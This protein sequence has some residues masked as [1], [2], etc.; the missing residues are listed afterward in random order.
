[1]AEVRRFTIPKGEVDHIEF[2][3]RL[4]PEIHLR[5]EKR[6]KL[7]SQMKHR[8]ELG[9]GTAVYI[10]G[11][12][13]D[14]TSAGI[15]EIELEESLSVLKQIAADC[16]ASVVK[17]E[18]F[19]ENGGVIAKVL[20]SSSAEPSSNHVVVSVAGHVNHGKSTFLAC[21]ITGEKD[22]GRK[23]LY[24]DT[25]PH[26]VERNLSADLHFAVLG[27]KENRPY[28]VKNPLD[29]NERSRVMRESDKIVSF[30]DTVG[31]E[32][33][34]RTTIRG[35]L[36][37]EIDYGILVIAADDG[38]THITREH[39]GIMLAM[40]LP[41]AVC[42]TKI[43]KVKPERVEA[44]EKEV[45]SLLKRV[46][47]IPISINSEADISL[48][49]DKLAVV[50]PLLKTSAVSREG[51]DLVYNFLR[52]LPVRPRRSDQP[53]LLYVD[54]V[55]NVEGV[56]A[57]VSG[58]VKQGML[59]AGSELLIGPTAKGRY[60]KVRAR[61]IEMHYTRLTE[62]QPGCIVG[63]AVKGVREDLIKR[64][65]VLCDPSLEPRSVWSFEADV[66]VL[67]HPTRIG[68]GYEPIVHAHTIASTARVKMVDK[69]Y[70]KAGES[71]KVE[72]RFKYR[73][74]YLQTGDR[75]VFRE[76]KTKGIG[77]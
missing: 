10:L 68:D 18:R 25:L 4:I 59:R 69:P 13:D 58:S 29:R 66:T 65:M 50:V 33:W 61:S 42:I 2:K 72:M 11:V 74:F 36:G 27:F 60:V 48:V 77:V 44:V 51:Y 46:G 1:M 5:V 41:V 53:F 14:G 32:P 49:A 9:D 54:R 39:L 7:A 37:Q 6:Q 31:H 3:E 21:L 22:D 8:L 67:S 64:G 63:I 26:E 35:L 55:Y 24:L 38:P 19:S 56:G 62:A 16:G 52:S 15:S 47:R 76:G 23:W 71:G 20:L 75:F 34:L 12:R 57:V 30:V 70:L 43:D 73:P 17:V 45:S 28:F 40:E